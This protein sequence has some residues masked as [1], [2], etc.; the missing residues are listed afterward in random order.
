ME[1]REIGAKMQGGGCW[2]KGDMDEKVTELLFFNLRHDKGWG[3]GEN[4]VQ[5]NPLGFPGTPLVGINRESMESN[6]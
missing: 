1:E 2:E 3:T 4:D 6:F 5:C